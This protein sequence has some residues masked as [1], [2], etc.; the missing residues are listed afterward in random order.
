[1]ESS[2]ELT[3]TSWE[4]ARVPSGGEAQCLISDGVS[5]SNNSSNNNNN[6]SSNNS[7]NISSRKSVSKCH[8]AWYGALWSQCFR[9]RYPF[10]PVLS[11]SVQGVSDPSE[12]ILER[13]IQ[14]YYAKN[15]QGVSNRCGPCTVT[16]T[17]LLIMSI[18][19]SSL[20][21]G[22]PSHFTCTKYST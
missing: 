4:G 15:P 9:A 22:Q 11:I 17:K 2:T 18:D 7:S 13:A 20:G 3:R 16:P 10:L 5:N 1:M 14:E 19:L 8:Q 12:E 6:S 21:Q